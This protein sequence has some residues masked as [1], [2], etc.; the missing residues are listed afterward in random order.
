MLA[1]RYQER[2]CTIPA[3]SL[4]L[5]CLSPRQQ[6]QALLRRLQGS[7]QAASRTI[8]CVIDPDRTTID[9]TA[10]LECG[11]HPARGEFGLLREFV[12]LE[13]GGRHL[14]QLEAV[15]DPL[16]SRDLTTVVWEPYGPQLAPEAVAAVADVALVDS[17]DLPDPREALAAA[18]R[19][20]EV[21]AVV[22]LAWQRS[23]IWRALGGGPVQSATL[24]LAAAGHL[25]ADRLPPARCS[26]SRAALR[27]VAGLASRMGSSAA[28]ARGRRAHRIRPSAQ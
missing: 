12:T 4:N 14:R 7:A 28:R 26:R 27:R 18:R 2:D 20:L 24:A 19:A 21:G 10:E 17:M 15:L 11:V 8:V 25:G 5:V 22:D 9:A 6:L 23:A 16:L 1:I 3:R 13:I